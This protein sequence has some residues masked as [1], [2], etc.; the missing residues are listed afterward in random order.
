MEKNDNKHIIKLVSL[1]KSIHSKNLRP[2]TE[3][4]VGE[5][6]H[7][8]EAHLLFLSYH[9]DEILEYWNGFI[10]LRVHRH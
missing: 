2:A 5:N 4:R 8:L 9:E 10:S 1:Q 3:I 6:N 7:S